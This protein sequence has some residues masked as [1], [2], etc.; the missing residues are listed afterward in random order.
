MKLPQ[1]LLVMVLSFVTAFAVAKY[2][3]PSSD[4]AA[5]IK[6]S[7]YDRVMRTGVLRCGYADSPPYT[8]VKDPQS[9]KVMGVV[10]DIAEAV[11]DKLG[12]KVE[13]AEDTGWANLIESLRT[14]RTDVFCAGLWRDATR[15]RLVTYT[16]PMFYVAVYPYVTPE[17]HRFDQD[18][19]LIDNPAVRLS[20]IDGQ[21]S[22]VIAK[23]NFPKATTVS[24]P[25]N[26]QITESFLNV[27]THKADV[28][29]NT[30]TA[31]NAFMKANPNT[32]RLAQDKPF[33]IFPSTFGVEIHET[34]LRDMLDSALIELQNQGIVDSIV[35]SYTNDTHEF[36]HVALPY[37]P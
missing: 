20:V 28:V 19:S 12:L 17:D 11:G 13:W 14:H 32:L 25:G 26:S 24:L 36:L 16:S 29:F 10:H 34:Q 22:E 6:E 5:S 4:G 2:V 30:P 21:M 23:K 37:K 8:L 18:L 7:A 35:E 1:I 9:G 33:K 27:A 31:V 3:V 15:G